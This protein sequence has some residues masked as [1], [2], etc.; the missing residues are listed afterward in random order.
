MRRVGGSWFTSP[1][2]ASAVTG[3]RREWV[4]RI[5]DR[6]RRRRVG[7][8]P[9]TGFSDRRLPSFSFRAR[10][11]AQVRF[12]FGNRSRTFPRPSER[13]RSGGGGGGRHWFPR[14]ASPPKRPAAVPARRP[15]THLS[16]HGKRPARP[17][18]PPPPS[19]RPR[20]ADDQMAPV[21]PPN[22]HTRTVTRNDD[23]RP[24]TAGPERAQRPGG[25]RFA[26]PRRGV[27]GAVRT[28]P[29][30]EHRPCV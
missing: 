2:R 3:S 4:V 18:V 27:A 16:A 21:F 23:D 20:P 1:R 5:S 10:P 28:A 30:V 9:C 8:S 29:S 15:F 7:G 19:S 24:P 11:H 17:S 26:L 12:T 22:T 25:V 6:R 13:E 14:R